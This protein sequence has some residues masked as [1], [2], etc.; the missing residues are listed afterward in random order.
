MSKDELEAF[1]LANRPIYDDIEINGTPILFSE[2]LQERLEQNK[3]WKEI[4]QEKE[5]SPSVLSAK[6]G[7]YKK[8]VERK[9]MKGDGGAA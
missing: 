6:W 8:W 2:L 3:T 9:M 5:V 7:A 4:A 1:I